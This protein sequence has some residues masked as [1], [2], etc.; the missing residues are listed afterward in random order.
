MKDS[1]IALQSE[2]GQE[3]EGE[4][5]GEEGPRNKMVFIA[6]EINAERETR[7]VRIGRDREGRLGVAS[8]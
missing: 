6:S 4:K 5:G 8:L 3:G 1:F 2:E 7:V